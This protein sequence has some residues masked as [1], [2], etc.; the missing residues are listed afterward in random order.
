MYQSDKKPIVYIVGKRTTAT[1]DESNI[2]R[3]RGF[4]VHHVPLCRLPMYDNGDYYHA[5]ATWRDMLLTMLYCRLARRRFYGDFNDIVNAAANGHNTG[6][7]AYY[8]L[9]DIWDRNLSGIDSERLGIIAGL[10][11]PGTRSILDVGCGNGKVTDY[12]QEGFTVTGLDL[13]AT[14]LRQ[15]SSPVVRASAAAIPFADRS[16]DAIVCT[17]LLEHLPPPAY[18]QAREEIARVAGH[19][20]ILELPNAQQLS[21]GAERCSRCGTRFH[22]NHHYRSFYGHN[23]YSLPDFRGFALTAI[24]YSTSPQFR[25]NPVL[26]RLRQRLAGVYMKSPIAYCTICGTR[27]FTSGMREN[28][29]I[30][31]WC[32]RREKKGRE[33]NPTPCPP[34]QVIL[35]YRRP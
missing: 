30:A 32:N 18:S 29:A 12:L 35:L 24:R 14:A 5:H 10:I 13:S 21:H 26:L 7:A 31:R 22:A 8:E 3:E 19:A 17:E 20:I 28:N 23:T 4:T 34:S 11:P 2:L 33:R 25:Y 6:E 16:F 27:Q 15:V 9:G 1:Q